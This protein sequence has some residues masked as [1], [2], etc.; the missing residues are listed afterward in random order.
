MSSY[1]GPAIQR[2]LDELNITQRQFAEMSGVDASLLNRYV[3]GDVRPSR[4]VLEKI[5]VA[6]EA[7][8]NRSAVALA[9][10]RDELPPSASELIKIVDLV[11]EPES[12]LR[13]EPEENQ[14]APKLPRKAAADFRFLMHHAERHPEVI[15]WIRATV[16]VLKGR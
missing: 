9:H 8:R 3:S 10:L 15:E 2:I 16:D 5:C 14:P 13:E 1:L 6:L 12:G 11:Q 4:E 7:A